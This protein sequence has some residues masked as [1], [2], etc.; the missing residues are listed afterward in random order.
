METLT[1]QKKKEKLFICKKKFFPGLVV[2][3]DLHEKELIVQF[4]RWKHFLPISSLITRG[5]TAGSNG[6]DRYVSTDEESEIF[7]SH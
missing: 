5:N 3:F 2:V 4:G 6:S 1:L 7:L